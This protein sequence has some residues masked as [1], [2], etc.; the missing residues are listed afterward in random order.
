MERVFRNHARTL[1]HDTTWRWWEG[2]ELIVLAAV[3]LLVPFGIWLVT[4]A[5]TEPPAG[6]LLRVGVTTLLTIIAF[7]KGVRAMMWVSEEVFFRVL[8][9]GLYVRNVLRFA[10]EIR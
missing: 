7:R 8:Q 9:P 3:M 1:A 10:R 4:P 5:L 6:G 2:A